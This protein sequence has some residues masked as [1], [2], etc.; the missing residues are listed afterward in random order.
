[1]S[2]YCDDCKWWDKDNDMYCLHHGSCYMTHEGPTKFETKHETVKPFLKEAKEEGP[3]MVNHPPHYEREGAMECINEM[4]LLFGKEA[5]KSFCL[6]NTWKYR[7]RA[8]AKNGVEDIKKS[9]WY[10]KKYQELSG[11]LISSVSYYNYYPSSDALT[12]TE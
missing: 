8:N 3:D 12:Y 1:M 7:Y 6:C 2:S 4:V 5:V 11:E 9:D 10:I